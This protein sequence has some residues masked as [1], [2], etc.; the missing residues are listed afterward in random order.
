[1]SAALLLVSFW[2]IL[3]G[4]EAFFYGDYCA[5]AYPLAFFD[6]V[7]F[8]HYE[9]PFWDPLNDCGIP[10]LA[11]WDS[12]TLYPF[13]AFYALLPMPWSLGTFSVLHLLL[14]SMGMYYLT[15]R[16]T[17]NQASS[18]IAGIVFSFNGFTF[19][20]LC[21]VADTATL[22]WAPWVMLTIDSALNAG[23]R[24]LFLA[25]I[26]AAMQMLAG[27]PEIVF[28][29]WC[30]VITFWLIGCAKCDDKA[31]MIIKF[32]VVVAL[33]ACLASVQL[34]PFLDLLLHSQR[35]D[36]YGG[37][38]WQMPLNGIANFLV[39]PFHMLRNSEGIF[40]FYDQQ[41]ISS[42]YMGVGTIAL[43]LISIQSDN[44]R[45]CVL[46][47]LVTFGILMAM[48]N[49]LPV[50]PAIK[51]LVPQIGYMRYPVKFLVFSAIGLPLLAGIGFDSLHAVSRFQRKRLLKIALL[52]VAILIFGIAVVGICECRDP[53]IMDDTHYVYKCAEARVIYLISIVG[54][55]LLTI[56][57]IAKRFLLTCVIVLIFLD[58]HLQ[59]AMLAP[60]VAVKAYDSNKIINDRKWDVKQRVAPVPF[61]EDYRIM[62]ISNY[63]YVTRLR[64]LL[65]GDINILDSLPSV[66]GGFPLKTAPQEMIEDQIAQG[67]L[68]GS[69]LLEFLCVEHAFVPKGIGE[70]QHCNNPMS[71]VSI[72]QR[73]VFAN[74]EITL[75]QILNVTFHP[76]ESVYLPEKAES[77]IVA[78][79]CL[80]A[81]IENA[82]LSPDR[83]TVFVDTPK[84]TMLVVAETYYHDWRA[85]IDGH[86]TKLWRANYNFQAVQVPPGR[87]CVRLVYEDDYFYIGLWIS[88]ITVSVCFLGC[89]SLASVGNDFCYS[90]GQ[91]FSPACN[92]GRKDSSGHTV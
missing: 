68:I 51:R 89:I 90:L 59:S 12:A 61:L 66:Y 76:D 67:S 69:P 20:E 88:L 75:K 64:G 38:I 22:A 85:Y 30:M 52:N 79:R 45:S 33:T 91:R 26:V 19:S 7:C 81:H 23:G 6:R 87:H 40:T 70:W 74:E 56:T 29:T 15:N 82:Q 34:L 71:I 86:A 48:G 47:G 80:E 77:L 72:G 18:A 42:Y 83:M 25:A 13:S 32:L 10:F 41:W 24:R 44:W 92:F 31:Q 53:R 16:W 17:N 11:Q 3:V 35:S 65:Y 63:A 37:F 46:W 55:V 1:M 36:V 14:G 9:I 27:T 5:F 43:A 8:Y 28:F 39:P 4:R 60:S 49:N 58:L 2:N 78:R 21:R 62:P 54:C 57:S 84:T 73:P 50:F